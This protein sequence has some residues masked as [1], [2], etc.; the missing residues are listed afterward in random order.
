MSDLSSWISPGVLHCLAWT[1]IHFVWQGIAEAALIAVFMGCCTRS[2]TRYVLAV[3]GLA[4]MLVTPLTT[5]LLLAN[6]SATASISFSTDSSTLASADALFIAARSVLMGN[7]AT[8]PFASMGRLPNSLDA[9]RWLVEAWLI[10]VA[11]FSLRLVVGFAFLEDK[12]QKWS[13]SPEEY[14]LGLCGQLQRRLGLN[15]TIR[16]VECNWLRAPAVVGWIRPV[17]LLPVIAL[18]GLSEEQLQAVIAHELAHIQRV[19]CFVNLFQILV[20]TLLFYHPAVWWLNKRIR[21]EREICCDEI[22]VSL[23]GNPIAYGRALALMEEWKSAPAL[24]VSASGG[25]L[26][27]RIFYLLGGRPTD[28]RPR[29]LGLTGGLLLLGAALAAGNA[30]FGVAFANSSVQPSVS[31]HSIA[32]SEQVS[33]RHA[34][35]VTSSQMQSRHTNAD[36][37][38]RISNYVRNT[39]SK[40]APQTRFAFW[41]SRHTGNTVLASRLIHVAEIAPPVVFGGQ[42]LRQFAAIPSIIPVVANGPQIPEISALTKEPDSVVCRVPQ[43]LPGS[44]FYGPKVCMTKSDWYELNTLG[45]DIGPDG[46]QIVE[47]D[48]YEKQRLRSSSGCMTS[49]GSPSNGPILPRCF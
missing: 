48:D 14:V 11:I 5:F 9:F 23:C 33:G 31:A 46:R 2:G 35:Q 43:Q 37:A 26:S 49:P 44:R 32:P 3:G 36:R 38:R 40:G 39:K 21:A 24:V 22:A 45:K 18:T 34:G 16:Y 29:V 42:D 17:I 41:K 25:L 19:D 8:I 28:I 13:A 15:R 27:E 12:R 30:L 47:N 6:A 1:L 20:E 10:G 7:A 4:V